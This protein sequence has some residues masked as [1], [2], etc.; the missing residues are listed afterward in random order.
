MDHLWRF[1]QNFVIPSKAKTMKLFFYLLFLVAI[2][3]FFGLSFQNQIQPYFFLPEHS[4]KKG[5][6]QKVYEVIAENLEI[7]W[8]IVFLPN[9]EILVS[10][11]PGRIV[12]LGKKTQAVQMKNIQIYGESGLLGMTLHPNFKQNQ[13]IY[14]Y[15]TTKK[16][17]NV[18]NRVERY[19]YKEG[20]LID[21][22]L[23]IDEIPGAIYHDGGRIAFGPDGYLYITTG[24]ANQAHLAQNVN[25]LAG[26]ILRVKDDG[27]IPEDNPFGNAVYSYGHRNPQGLTWDS[28]L[29]LWSTEHGASG[30]DEVTQIKKGA[31]YGWPVIRGDEKKEGMQSPVLHSGDDTWAPASALYWK[32]SIFFGGLRGQALFE[33]KID[34]NP[35][36]LS[37]HFKNQFG[38]IRTVSMGPDGYFYILTSNRDGRGFPKK[39]DDRIIRIDPEIFR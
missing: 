25:S 38:R 12:S 15:Y 21:P 34:K 30:Q 39:N 5:V 16:N 1:C 37:A 8:D 11:R 32:G 28:S 29:Q 22:T 19:V 18:Y 17:G 13:F 24:D 9:S 33:A 10:E 36:E 6:S 27:R 4:I 31:N 2:F 35:I 14:L 20:K 7:P 23:I 3:L 26:K